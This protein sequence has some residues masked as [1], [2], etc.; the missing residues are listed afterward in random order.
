ML[1]HCFRICNELGCQNGV[2]LIVLY[3]L[4]VVRVNREWLLGCD[5]AFTDYVLHFSS[6]W[7]HVSVRVDFFRIMKMLLVNETNFMDYVLIWNLLTSTSC[8]ENECIMIVRKIVIWK[9]PLKAHCII[10]SA[11]AWLPQADSN[12]IWIDINSYCL[13]FK[14]PGA[15]F[16]DIPWSSRRIFCF[17]PLR[18]KIFILQDTPN[19]MQPFRIIF[20]GG[21]TVFD[22]TFL[23]IKHKAIILAV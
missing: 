1:Y 7:P 5:C 11:F 21:T 23:Y 17:R 3:Q 8:N 12:F 9:I 20:S 10:I 15:R 14:V 6:E 22:Y 4:C 16:R 13:I 19:S 18:I 2:K